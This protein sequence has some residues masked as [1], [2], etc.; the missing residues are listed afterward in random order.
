MSWPYQRIRTSRAA[1]GA[2]FDL[3]NGASDRVLRL[4]RLLTGMLQPGTGKRARLDDCATPVNHGIRH[5]LARREAAHRL[6]QLDRALADFPGVSACASIERVRAGQPDETLTFAVAI[7]RT[8]LMRE[9]IEAF[10]YVNLGP[11][12]VP[13]D[14]LFVDAIPRDHVGA[15]DEPALLALLDRHAGSMSSRAAPRPS[16]RNAVIT[17]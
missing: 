12:H 1:T 15:V 9:R 10:L 16:A 3:Q 2:W 17:D 13:D 11:D 6:K 14:V 5:R 4:G 8:A 7:A